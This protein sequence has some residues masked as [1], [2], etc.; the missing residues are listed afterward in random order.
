VAEGSWDFPMSYPFEMAYE[1]TGEKGC[2]RFSTSASPSLVF[3]P[4]DGEPFTPQFPATTGYV[5][6]ME[7]FCQCIRDNVQPAM[8]TPFSAR[9]SIRVIM[10]E[11]AAIASGQVVGL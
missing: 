8:V 2:L 1:V 6:E 9:E 10:A 4:T 7:Y 3:H 5:R 11:A